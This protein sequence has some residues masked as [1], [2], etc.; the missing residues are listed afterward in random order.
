MSE[1]THRE[2]Q[3]CVIYKIVN[4]INN[5]IYIGQ[6]V[7]L[8]NRYKRHEYS[9]DVLDK[10]NRPI[11]A[12]FKKYGF[13]NFSFIVIE[14]VPCDIKKLTE[15]EQYWMDKLQS[16]KRSIG[17]NACPAA[18]SPFGYK[19]SKETRAKVSAAN[20]GRK[21]TIETK[22]K[23]SEVHKGKAVSIETRRKI[24]ESKKG[25]TPNR[26]YGKKVIQIDKK[27][28]KQITIFKSVTKAHKE[29]GI[30]LGN[31]ARSCRTK[32]YSAGGFLWRY[33]DV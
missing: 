7:N 11:V 3:I 20:K 12:A 5:K 10:A 30:H 23:M 26:I 4:N 16:H 15:R 29:T 14:E 32:V 25:T 27:T 21:H 8:Y 6:T 13:N 22:K 18:G 17:Y 31:I 2:H 28:N 19:H 9:V 33:V 24:S 1:I